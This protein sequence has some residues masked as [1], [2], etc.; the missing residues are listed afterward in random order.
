MS[1]SVLNKWPKYWNTGD[2]ERVRWRQVSESSYIEYFSRVDNIWRK[3]EET[4]ESIAAD[5][6]LHGFVQTD[7]QGNP[8]DLKKINDGY[9]FI[10][11][12]WI[13]RAAD[14]INAEVYRACAFLKVPLVHVGT[15]HIERIIARHYPKAEANRSEPE[16]GGPE[17]FS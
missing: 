6:G 15:S 17:I 8:L 9:M 3:S 4:P 13:V 10:P 12:P 1:D 7:E 16:V 11:E 14:E 2:D 5:R